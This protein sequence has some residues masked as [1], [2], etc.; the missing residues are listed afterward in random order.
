VTDLLGKPPPGDGRTLDLDLLIGEA[1]VPPS[2]LPEA[3]FE[4]I[5]SEAAFTRL[6]EGWAEWLL[7]ARRLLTES[8]TL[9]VALSEPADFERPTGAGWSDSRIGMT[10][11]WDAG[12]GGSETVFHSEWWLRAHW[13]RAFEVAVERRGARRLASLRKRPGEFT[14]EDLERPEPGDGRELAA[15]SANV[16]YL[17]TQ[18]EDANRRHRDELDELREDMG[19]ELMRRSF[20]AADLEWARR[21]PGSPATLLAAEYEATTS[22]RMTKP[23]RALGSM[24]RR[25]R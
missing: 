7:E 19:R 24:L 21:G 6:A 22:W 11:L 18:I 15:A 3:S 1:R 8:G 10:V 9:V 12:G 4:L 5:W 25:L 20:V 2:S 16:A 13:G 17:R 14:G 23:L